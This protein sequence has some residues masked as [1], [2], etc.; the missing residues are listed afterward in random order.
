M[1]AI[2]HDR[3]RNLKRASYSHHPVESE[4]HD[5]LKRELM[6]LGKI[7]KGCSKPGDRFVIGNCA[8]QHAA[9]LYM[10]QYGENN[11][12]NLYFTKAMRPRTKQERVYCDNCK[13]T[14]P[15]L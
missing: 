2:F 9:N 4:F 1:A 11:L 5:V 12:G 8:E 6:K 14:F 3:G 7:G 10:K 13:D 15:N